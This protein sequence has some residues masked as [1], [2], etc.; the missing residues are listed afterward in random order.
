MCLWIWR[1]LERR[2]KHGHGYWSQK[3]TGSRE[4]K[5][6]VKDDR[7]YFVST[8]LDKWYNIASP[9]HPK[10]VDNYRSSYRHTVAVLGGKQ[11]KWNK[12]NLHKAWFFSLN[13]GCT[14]QYMQCL[15]SCPRSLSGSSTHWERG[16][17]CG[18]CCVS[19]QLSSP[20]ICP[21]SRAAAA[22]W[23]GP[24][25]LGRSCDSFVWLNDFPPQPWC[26]Y[27]LLEGAADEKRVSSPSGS[28]GST[29]SQQSLLG[30]GRHDCVRRQGESRGEEGG[31][32]VDAG[33]WSSQIAIFCW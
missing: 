24:L 19:G 11:R 6:D 14:V 29:N 22:E 10:G 9:G 20:L 18:P 1:Y 12:K 15:P 17:L 26:H 5:K 7:I 31:R 23:L 16:L 25:C 28:R 30:A 21:S 13:S 32:R 2:M 3:E 27:V 4:E 33:M 8:R